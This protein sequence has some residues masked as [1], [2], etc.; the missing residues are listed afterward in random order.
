MI[1]RVVWKIRSSRSPGLIGR[2]QAGCSLPSSYSRA[3]M[4]AI[5]LCSRTIRTS[6]AV[7]PTVELPCSS[8]TAKKRSFWRSGTPASRTSSRKSS[9]CRPLNSGLT[10]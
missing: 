5:R 8:P 7:L 2:S 3:R 10:A 6:S 4:P 1:M 9:S